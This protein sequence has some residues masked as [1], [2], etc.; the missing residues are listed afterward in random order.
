MRGYIEFS[1]LETEYIHAKQN[2][3]GLLGGTF[4]PIHNGHI[5]MAYI[6]L[7]EFLLGKVVFLPSGNPPHKKDEY[8]A[9]ADVRFDMIR[10]ATQDEPRFCI[11]RAEIDRSGITYTVDTLSMLA[12]SSKGHGVLLHYRCRHVV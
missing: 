12:R 3:V 6:V 4:N 9:P 10:L 11:S 8:V 1:M 7:Y 5:S 2:K